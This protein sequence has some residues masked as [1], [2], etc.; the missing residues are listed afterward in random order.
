LTLTFRLASAGR[1]RFAVTELAP[2]CREIGSFA[3]AGR[4]GVNRVLLRGRVGSR[5]LEP[6]TY[7]LSVRFGTH[8]LFGV[9]IVVAR[10]L[11]RR[12]EIAPAIV[13]D[14]CAVMSGTDAFAFTQSPGGSIAAL[15]SAGPSVPARGGSGATPQS[16]SP[17]ASEALGAQFA[18]SLSDRNLTMLLVLAAVAVAIALLGAAAIPDQFIPYSPLGAMLLKRR[19]E[20]ALAGASTLLVA[21]IAYLAST[22]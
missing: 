17:S 21:V 22:R 8:D 7:L 4:A 10:G 9:R 6:G 2:A 11:V 15:A 3:I 14:P 16:A 5:R 18:R 1:V 20:I 19:I 13:S 12:A